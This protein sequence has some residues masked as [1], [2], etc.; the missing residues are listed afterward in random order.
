MEDELLSWV[1]Y[2]SGP[3]KRARV[4]WEVEKAG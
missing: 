4:E 3:D 1:S 2:L